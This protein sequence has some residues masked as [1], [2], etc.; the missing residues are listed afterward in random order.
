MARKCF[1]EAGPLVNVS[2]AIIQ[3]NVLIP[4]SSLLYNQQFKWNFEKSSDKHHA[5]SIK[6]ITFEKL[7]KWELSYC[8]PSPFT[9][10]E[11]K[12][13]SFPLGQVRD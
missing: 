4:A 3:E 8:I 5:L 6:Y 10:E 12:K 7:G 13:V 2:I 11:M 9:S 1:C